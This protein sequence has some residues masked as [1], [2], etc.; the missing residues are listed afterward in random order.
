[1][2]IKKLPVS[3]QSKEIFFMKRFTETVCHL[4]L[5][6]IPSVLKA[7]EKVF[8]FAVI[9]KKLSIRWQLPRKFSPYF[10]VL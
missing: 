8:L 2:I 4:V 9:S 7:K 1:M 5:V 6:L 10:D 3:E